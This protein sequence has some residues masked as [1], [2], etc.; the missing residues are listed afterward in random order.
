MSSSSP[1]TPTIALKKFNSVANYEG[2]NFIVNVGE[3]II[4]EITNYY[5]YSN[6]NDLKFEV[7]E[8]DSND[9]VTVEEIGALPVGTREWRRINNKLHCR[10]KKDNKVFRF[11]VRAKNQEHWYYIELVHGRQREGVTSLSR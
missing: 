5:Q 3:D 7:S 9:V 4:I 2:G 8:T 1:N 6:L 10:A 11:K